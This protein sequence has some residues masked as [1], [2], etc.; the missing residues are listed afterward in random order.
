MRPILFAA[1]V[2]GGV[3]LLGSS[4]APG[5]GRWCSHGAGADNCGFSSYEQCRAN[6]AGIGGKCMPT[7]RAAAAPVDKPE[8]NEP[9]RFRVDPARE[10]RKQRHVKRTPAMRPAATT[11]VDPVREK[12]RDTKRSATK[13]DSGM[14]PAQTTG[15]STRPASRTSIPLPDQALLTPLPEFDC[16]FKTT[17]IDG[18]SGQSQAS[19]TRGQTD[20]GTEA[21]LRMRLDYE[22]QCYKQ[23]EMILRNRLHHLQASVGDTI[24]ATMSSRPRP[25]IPLPEQALLAPIPEFDCEFKPS[26][27]DGA[28]DTALRM[29]L[30][31]ERQCYKHAETILRDRLRLLQASIG[32]TIKAAVL[33]TSRTESPQR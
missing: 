32:E 3:C 4:G 29:K 24:K 27:V 8:L 6:I 28:T 1:T 20:P 12:R 26:T 5:Q 30:D 25:T 33:G 13:Q 22:R 2:I 10:K 19:G 31:Y 11:E 15:I 9:A 18:A 17:S 23:A 7:D 14:R 21:A 16:A